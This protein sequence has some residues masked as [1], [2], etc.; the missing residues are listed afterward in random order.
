MHASNS[1]GMVRF[2]TL[3][4]KEKGFEKRSL[5]SGY[6]L[7]VWRPRLDGFNLK[8]LPFGR[9]A[10]WLL[11][12]RLGLFSN[13]LAGVIIIK[14]AKRIVHRSLVTPKWYRFPD[15]SSSDLQIGDVWTS[16][17]ERGRGLA[18]FAINEI[19][20]QWAPSC[21]TM[22]YLVSDSNLESINLIES[23]G[24]NLIALGKRTNP[25]KIHALG[26]FRITNWL[27]G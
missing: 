18:K 6:S 27:S 10:I 26:R 1:Y 20:R 16:E 25:G 5:P 15:M 8:G 22:W 9:Y 7:E 4:I 2:Y 24:Y 11:F 3:A 23:F 14:K 17:D 12:D 13:S 21:I 19:H